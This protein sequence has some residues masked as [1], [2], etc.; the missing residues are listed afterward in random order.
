MPACGND[1]A[2]FNKLDIAD[3]VSNGA[4]AARCPDGAAG[5]KPVAENPIVS[6]AVLPVALGSVYVS[7]RP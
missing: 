3:I 1:A 5:F 2:D 4:T 6:P 7:G